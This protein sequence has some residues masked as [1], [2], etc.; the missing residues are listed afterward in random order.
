MKLTD[1]D[2][3]ETALLSPSALPV[4]AQ[5]P[6]RIY[7]FF[8]EKVKGRHELIMT[9]QQLG[10]DQE[11]HVLAHDDLRHDLISLGKDT[12]ELIGTELLLYLRLRRSV[13]GG[14]EH[15]IRCVPRMPEGQLELTA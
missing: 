13:S 4:A 10:D 2:K 5:V 15:E 6:V 14:M 8:E 3:P 11:H 1:Y 7:G 9:V 12:D